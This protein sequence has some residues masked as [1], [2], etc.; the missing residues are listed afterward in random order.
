[1]VRRPIRQ[2][3]RA[4]SLAWPTNG[5]RLWARLGQG[6]PQLGCALGHYVGCARRK[7]KRL[8]GE[9]RPERVLKKEILFLFQIFL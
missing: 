2:Q 5:L 9:I 4:A 6:G 8:A 1:M 3:L 7:G